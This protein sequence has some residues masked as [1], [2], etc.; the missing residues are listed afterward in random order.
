MYILEGRLRH[1]CD[2]LT[3]LLIHRL[4]NELLMHP[5]PR[6]CEK[7]ISLALSLT[8]LS[9]IFSYPTIIKQTFIYPSLFLGDNTEVIRNNKIFNSMVSFTREVDH[10]W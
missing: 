1:L 9:L 4:E 2:Q 7:P 6:T 3:F 5:L 8:Y 10:W